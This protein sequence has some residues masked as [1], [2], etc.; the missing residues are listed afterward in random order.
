MILEVLKPSSRDDPSFGAASAVRRFQQRFPTAL[1]LLLAR[2]LWHV[3]LGRPVRSAA[4]KRIEAAD[5]QC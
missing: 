5:A 4:I 3:Y 1:D 2:N